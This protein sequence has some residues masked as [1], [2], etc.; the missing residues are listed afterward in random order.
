[1]HPFCSHFNKGKCCM[2]WT[3]F[4]EPRRH[5][6]T[7]CRRQEDL[8]I[9]AGVELISNVLA[10]LTVKICFTSLLV[11]KIHL[12]QPYSK[13][14]HSKSHVFA[15]QRKHSLSWRCVRRA[16]SSIKQDIFPQKP[17]GPSVLSSF[18]RKISFG[19]FAQFKSIRQWVVKPGF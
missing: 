19:E 9:L 12:P 5:S 2:S 7:I 11:C 8:E 1:M 13:W 10:N 6:S 18:D 3:T 14:D 4:K 16:T 15:Y 17:L